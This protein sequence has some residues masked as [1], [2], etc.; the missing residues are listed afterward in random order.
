MKQGY[1][2]RNLVDLRAGYDMASER[3]SQLLFN[4]PV[5][6][7]KEHKGYIKVYQADGYHGWI[8]KE[9][10]I[11]IGKN[12]SRDYRRSINY[13]VIGK[14]VTIRGESRY[15]PRMLFY[16]TELKARKIS[17]ERLSVES[18]DGYRFTLAGRSAVALTT[19]AKY[20]PTGGDIIRE[21][22]KFPG[23]PYLWGGT[24]P[25]GFDCSG[26]VRAVLDRFGIYVPRDSKDQKR[27]GHKVN[28]EEIMAGDLLFFPG[29]VA[30]AVDKYRI[31]HAS[32]REGGVAFNSL[33]PEAPDFRADLYESLT[34]I[35]RILK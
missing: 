6:V 25:F 30:I 7:G 23:I 18:I 11:F 5:E 28:R 4:E 14:T 29:H 1:I 17:G 21:A 2:I 9:A 3:R 16:G 34:D 12:R 15:A 13:K 33:K 27:F 35:R 20:K 31:I 22:G 10:L 24:S 26:L 8:R 19:I 32:A